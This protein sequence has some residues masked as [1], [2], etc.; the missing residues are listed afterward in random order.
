MSQVNIS[1]RQFINMYS[2]TLGY[3]GDSD[4]ALNLIN[5]ARAIAYPLGDWDGSLSLRSL[6][7]V[8]G[9]LILPSKYETIKS[10]RTPLGKIDIQNNI[11]IDRSFYDCCT[12][13]SIT[14][15]IDRS[16]LPF[17]LTAGYN[18]F[19]RILKDQDIGS[20]IQVSYNDTHGSP[21]HETIKLEEK[22]AKLSYS[23]SVINNIVKDVTKASVMVSM[24]KDKKSAPIAQG[25]IYS[26]ERNPTYSIY[27]TNVNCGYILV[28]AKKKYIPY[29]EFDYDDPIDINP[30]SL[31]SFIIAAKAQSERGE[32]WTQEYS[33]SVELGVNFLRKEAH[34]SAEINKAAEEVQLTERA[35][36]D[37]IYLSRI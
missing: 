3:S 17:Q 31:V 13:C 33:Q 37:L 6:P 28:E 1:V 30:V 36:D 5:Q 15:M 27:C 20:L 9:K 10:A 2:E 19:F 21:R 25:L 23:P 32:N 35:Y 26:N 18:L 8:N 7:V 14:K 24:A 11:F 34:D 12:P 29:N 16:Y 22:P 4:C